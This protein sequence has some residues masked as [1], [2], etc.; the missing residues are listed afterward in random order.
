MDSVGK[1]QNHL[2]KRGQLAPSRDQHALLVSRK[3]NTFQGQHNN[4][5]KMGLVFII[6]LI[7]LC[8]L[9]DLVY[10]HFK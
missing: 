8:R 6:H 5:K 7:T 9:I 1:Y 2:S 4:D 10:L 3:E